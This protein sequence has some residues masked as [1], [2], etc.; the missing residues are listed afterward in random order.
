MYNVSRPTLAS[1]DLQIKS[2]ALCEEGQPR[3]LDGLNVQELSRLT[4]LS[5]FELRQRGS[6]SYTHT[7]QI[8]HVHILLRNGSPTISITTMPK[9][10]SATK[11]H[12]PRHTPLHVDISKDSDMQK[13]GR[14]AS[15][16]GK[17][18][19]D[20]A[21]RGDV[22]ADGEDKE[23]GVV[24][25]RMSRKILDLARDQQEEVMGEMEDDDDDEDEEDD[26]EEEEDVRAVGTGQRVKRPD[27]DE[28]ED[29]EEGDVSDE[30]YAE[31]VSHVIPAAFLV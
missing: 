10:T 9:A 16:N 19:K 28:E 20:R 5:C 25:G 24:G 8:T 21:S 23:G 29:L 18:G 27:A 14:V 7:L 12:K 26:E 6:N 11:N 2:S 3:T 22:E 1:R 17:K 31:L 15:T 30:E 13:F 4:T